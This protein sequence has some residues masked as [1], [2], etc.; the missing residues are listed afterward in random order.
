[1]QKVEDIDAPL[2]VIKEGNKSLLVV[3]DPVMGI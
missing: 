1:M 2:D 3:D